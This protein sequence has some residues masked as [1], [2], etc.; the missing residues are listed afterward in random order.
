MQIEIRQSE[1]HDESVRV[2]GDAA[3]TDFE[4]TE[5][6]LDYME[7]VFDP[8]AYASLGAVNLLLSFGEILV[9]RGVRVRE[10][11]R[12]RSAQP[13]PSRLTAISGVT[14]DA[15]FVSV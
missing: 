13:E 15:R 14:P 11:G 7:S 8:S 9:A 1:V 12:A 2:L 6:A 5:D 10:I 4:E 3:I